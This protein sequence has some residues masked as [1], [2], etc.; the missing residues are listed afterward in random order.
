MRIYYANPASQVA[1][2]VKSYL[3]IY[4][5]ACDKYKRYILTKEYYNAIIRAENN[6]TLFFIP[7][8]GYK[9]QGQSLEVLERAIK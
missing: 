8:K 9:K 2:A 1:K 5:R 6:Y 7:D 3:A 4:I